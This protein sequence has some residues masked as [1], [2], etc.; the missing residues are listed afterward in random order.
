MV[1]VKKIRTQQGGLPSQW[2]VKHNGEE[3]GLLER[4]DLSVGCHPWKVYRG[5]GMAST[6]VG[7]FYGRR[8]QALEALVGPIAVELGHHS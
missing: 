2:L 3:V 4:Y 6:F 1:E 8:R 5:I 7:A